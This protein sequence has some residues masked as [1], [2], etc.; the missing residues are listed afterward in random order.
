MVNCPSCGQSM[1]IKTSFGEKVSCPAC[2]D[3]FSIKDGQLEAKKE[4]V[5]S[6]KEMKKEKIMGKIGDIKNTIKNGNTSS[7]NLE[8]ENAIN[9]FWNPDG[10]T[11]W[12]GIILVM[13]ALLGFFAGGTYFMHW[14][15]YETIV[16]DVGLVNVQGVIQ[17]DDGNPL[18]NVEIT[19]NGQN[20]T[21]TSNEQGRFYIYDVEGGI[22]EITFNLENY[23]EQTQKI[24]LEVGRINVVNAILEE[25]NCSSDCEYIDKTFEVDNP[26]EISLVLSV[27]IILFSVVTL[28][29]SIAALRKSDF[30]M[31]LIGSIAGILSYGFMLGSILSIVAMLMIFSDRDAFESVLNTKKENL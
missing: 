25:G 2:E 31:A 17:T 28:Y 13:V 24:E 5:D 30:S 23:E 29:G 18:E 1:K 10:N 8:Y 20:W 12:A 7:N 6:E 26:A 27:I 4:I 19:L 3:V 9:N 22:R 14:T 16:D 11:A 21:W 15:E